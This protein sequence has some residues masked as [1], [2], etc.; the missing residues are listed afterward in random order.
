MPHADPNPNHPRSVQYT[1]RGAQ[2]L[3][4][5]RFERIAVED[6]WDHLPSDDESLTG[7]R[8]LPT[9]YFADASQSI[10]VENNSPD[11]PFRFSVNP[12]RGCSHGLT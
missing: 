11:I 12:Y 9:E 2:I 3:P 8:K 1:G 10:V 4:A 6:D 5:N 7:E